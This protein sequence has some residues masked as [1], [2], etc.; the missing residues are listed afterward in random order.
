MLLL[1]RNKLDLGISR[2]AFVSKASDPI[3]AEMTCPKEQYPQSG[4]HP[5]AI[6]LRS[7]HGRIEAKSVADTGS[8]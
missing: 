2:E 4:L 6:F 1:A 8:L 3:F 7:I 5:A